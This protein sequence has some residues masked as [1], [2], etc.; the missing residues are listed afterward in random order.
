M[1]S[2]NFPYLSS[3]GK[4]GVIRFNWLITRFPIWTTLWNII[5]MEYHFY[6]IS[7]SSPVYRKYQMVVVVVQ[8]QCVGTLSLHLEFSF[9]SPCRFKCPQWIKE[10][11]CFWC[12]NKNNKRMYVFKRFVLESNLVDHVDPIL[13]RIILNM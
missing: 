3:I 13:Q 4:S 2:N 1:S 12:M 7:F 5:F 9:P 6:G 8:C 11:C 10:F